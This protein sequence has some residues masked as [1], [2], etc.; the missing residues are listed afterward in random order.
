ME[1][2]QDISE[3]YRHAVDSFVNNIKNDSSVIAVI[4]CGSFAYDTV[5]EKSDIDTTVVVKDMTLK[6]TEYCILVD[7]I[8]INVAL[9]T[10]SAFKRAMERNLGGSFVQSYFA[11]GKIIYTTEDS[12][13]E[14]FDELKTPGADDLSY[15]MFL[16]AAGIIG[17]NEKAEKWLRVKQEP[18]YAQYY[19]LKNAELIAR[20]ILFLNGESPTRECIQHAMK[21]DPDTMSLFYDKSMGKHLSSNE[22]EQRIQ[23]VKDYLARHIDSIKKPVIDYLSDGEM[24]SVTMLGKYFHA[25]GHFLMSILDFLSE[26]GVIE[27][28]TQTIRITPKGR[29]IV[30]EINYLYLPV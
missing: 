23:Y 10:R 22:L 20:F 26:Q 9:M 24:K 3:R 28:A 14:Y 17:Y 16:C 27:K 8:L 6:N 4:V 12:L 7:N 29:Q 19:M 18:L 1:N 5:W 11:K 30:E 15:S 21:Y 2:Q 25:E 13:Y